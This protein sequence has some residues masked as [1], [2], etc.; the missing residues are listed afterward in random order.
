LLK[1]CLHL[2]NPKSLTPNP[3]PTKNKQ[4]P[5]YGHAACAVGPRRL[6][7]F[8]GCTMGGYAGEVNELYFVDLDLRIDEGDSA[9]PARLR[10]LMGDGGPR[11]GGV[12]TWRRVHALGQPLIRYGRSL[13]VDGCE[14]GPFGRQFLLTSTNSHR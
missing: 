11:L 6:A 5:I 9:A 4:P 1:S 3:F 12:A 2:L 7:V 8:G 10:S 13:C 14:V